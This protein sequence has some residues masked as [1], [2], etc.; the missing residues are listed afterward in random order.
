MGLG[1]RRNARPRLALLT[2][3]GRPRFETRVADWLGVDEAQRRILAAASAL[4]AESVPLEQSLGRTLAADVHASARLPPWDNSA[5]DGYAV[6]AEDVEGASEDQPIELVVVGRIWAGSDDRP[7]LGPGEACRVMTGAPV[8]D[9]ADGVIRVEHTDR[10]AAGI[11]RVRV[12]SD[13]DARRNIRPGGQDMEVGEL[14]VAAG[15]RIHGG[16]I[17]ILAAAGRAEVSVYRPPRVSVLT[18][19][20]ELRPLAEFAD[21]AEGLAIPDTNGPML[22]AAVRA[23]GGEAVLI[24]PA[25]DDADDI[26]RRLRSVP[27]AD[28][29]V[30]IGGASMGEADL[31]KRVLEDDG[32]EVDF[33]RALMRPGSPLAFGHLPLPGRARPVPLVSLPGNPASAWVTFQLFVRPLLRALQ[34]DPSPHRP[35]LQA[36]TADALVSVE[37]LCHFH[38]VRIDWT[39]DP[40]V[41]LTGHQG[42]GLVHSVG[43]AAGLAVVPEGVARIEPGEPV[44]VILLGEGPGVSTPGFAARVT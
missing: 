34:G 24:G 12:R 43:P 10:E 11:D 5:M 40:T 29:I 30:T 15:T 23:A 20:D 28:V 1:T 19:G 33:W 25:K 37:R 9:G 38:R 6:R 36:R 18:G 26:R 7:A 3:D 44:E 17:A 14:V 21:V 8:P 32:L 2:L 22:A 42:S 35:V 16:W 31:L 27:D 4:S 41:H 13:H 39:G